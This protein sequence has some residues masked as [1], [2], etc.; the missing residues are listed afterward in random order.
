MAADT[1]FAVSS[2][3]PPAAIAVLRV[4]GAGSL[5]A[6]ARLAGRLPPPRHAAVRA[7]RDP[8]DN[9]LLDRALVLVFPGPTTA[10][11]ED[12]VEL[13]LHG[14]RAVVASV[15]RAL[16]GLP[17]LRAAEPGEFTRRALAHGRI[18]LTEAEGLGDLLSA[19]TEAQRQM[20]LANSDGRLRRAVADWTAT[21]TRLSAMIEAVLDHAD[22]DDVDTGS[23]VVV[24]IRGQARALS[25]TIGTVLAVPPVERLR[26]GI[27]VVLAGP[28][29][30]G[31]ST[32]LNALVGREA[33]IV[34]PVAGTTR[35]VIEIPVTR[36]G[37]AWLFLDTAGLREDSDDP[38]ERIGIERATGLIAGADVVLWLG[39]DAP[40]TEG[41][42]IALYPRAD[43]RE[44][45][46]EERIAVSAATGDGIDAVWTALTKEA[47]SLLPK[48]DEL[49]LN[50]RQA[51]HATSAAAALG[52]AAVQDDPLLLAEELRYAVQAFAALTGMRATEAVLDDLFG[53]FCIG[54]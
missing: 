48:V 53:R 21:A 8:V 10:T 17:G 1:I 9:R 30:A 41:R 11:G 26:D 36:E 35:D 7:L 45:A 33:A 3:R 54:K 13:H 39:D 27:R 18:D 15:E 32:L 43:I 31:K 38:I 28:P 22:E 25:E 46:V 50:R 4:S 52:R 19:E 34:S 20:A 40:P 51:H 24:T 37:V 2:G 12:L 16:A 29:N 6:A 47:A 5:D 14:G 42:V 44:A 23:D 49:A